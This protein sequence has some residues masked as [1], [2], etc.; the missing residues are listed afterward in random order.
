MPQNDD[1]QS[2]LN[3]DSDQRVDLVAWLQLELVLDPAPVLALAASACAVSAGAVSAAPVAPV[4]CPM[5]G[6]ALAGADGWLQCA[7]CG[8]EIDL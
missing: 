2:Q 1:S 4:R 5:C 6:A 3:S 7:K 8:M